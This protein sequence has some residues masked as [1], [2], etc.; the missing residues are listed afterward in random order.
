[1]GLTKEP[2]G[3]YS[4]VNQLSKAYGSYWPRTDCC[5]AELFSD[6]NDFVVQEI[7]GDDICSLNEPTIP[8][9]LPQYVTFT[10]VKRNISTFDCAKQIAEYFKIDE[11]EVTYS[12]LKDTHAITSQRISLPIT[13]FDLKNIKTSYTFQG[14]FLKD[15]MLTNIQIKQGSHKGNK[16]LVT[17]R[18]GENVKSQ[19]KLLKKHFLYLIKNGVPNIYGLQRFGPR[20][21]NHLIGK[22][23]VERD[24]EKA[25]RIW[26]TDIYNTWDIGK[27]LSENWGNWEKCINIISSNTELSMEKRFLANLYV[28]KD[29]EKAFS[30]I[31]L[32]SFFVRSFRSFLFNEALLRLI[33][34]NGIKDMPT[35]LECVGPD[36]LFADSTKEVYEEVLSEYDLKISDLEFANYPTF[37]QKGTLRQA[38]MFPT[39]TSINV[40]ENQ[41]KIGFS[42]P[43]GA[44]AT[45]LLSL[46]FRQQ[47]FSG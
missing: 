24:F 10:L 43:V 23:M 35:Y 11:R 27:N 15:P 47:D 37:T 42:L 5:S 31:P 28:E 2:D 30:S 34:K 26:L 45:V 1:M 29:F 41:L 9:K 7:I 4:I 44:Y 22:A 20:G 33:G 3:K 46:L 17:A 13:A 19:I 14:F 21:Y 8:N 25:A 18:I 16:F 39:D 12:G 6:E 40:Q 36:T 38:V 32:G